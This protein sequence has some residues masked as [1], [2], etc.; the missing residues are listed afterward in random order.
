MLEELYDNIF[1]FNDGSGF[2]LNKHIAENAVGRTQI[3]PNSIIASHYSSRSIYGGS[4]AERTILEE[5]LRDGIL[6]NEKFS[7]NPSMVKLLTNGEDLN[8]IVRDGLYFKNND[9]E[10][11]NAPKDI[12]GLG[13]G[14][15]LEVRVYNSRTLIQRIYPVNSSSGNIKRYN[16]E[17]FK[18]VDAFEEWNVVGN[19]VIKKIEIPN[20][21][22]L[23]GFLE[24]GYFL[25][26]NTYNYSNVP[27]E[28]EGRAFLLE[29]K[30]YG[31]NQMFIQ[32]SIKIFTAP[33]ISYKRVIRSGGSDPQVYE[34]KKDYSLIANNGENTNHPLAG[35][36]IICFGDSLTEF[37]DYTGKL[38]ESTGANVIDVGFGG[39]RMTSM[40]DDYPRLQYKEMSM[41]A[42]SETIKS[43]D[44]SNLDAAAK[45]LKDNYNDDNTAAVNRLKNTDFNSIDYLTVFYGTNDYTSAPPLGEPDS[46]IITEFNGAINRIVENI[47]SKYPHIKIIFLTPTWRARINVG[48]GQESDTTTNDLGLYLED[49]VDAIVERAHSHKLPA[50]NLYRNSGINKFTTT[51][52]QRDGLHLTDKGD[53]II[54]RILAHQLSG[55]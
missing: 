46:S 43:G 30:A 54:T 31:S 55:M 17:R 28:F 5:H 52:Y 26:M 3:A 7:D 40:E 8:T 42:L 13:V 10:V 47:Q 37:G 1:L 24:D 27:T 35:K 22:D 19:R 38:Q 39:C 44:F 6:S 18:R 23:D 53:E 2:I 29:N 49:Y 34:W 51:V 41:A 21:T 4:I 36:N 20:D 48:D 9:S 33:E 25:G 32:Q 11:L 12:G 50:I 15:L 45:N 16:H 14:F